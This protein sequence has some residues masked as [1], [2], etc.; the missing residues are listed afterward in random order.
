MS[1]Q[2]LHGVGPIRSAPPVVSG[3]NSDPRDHGHAVCDSHCEC[4]TWVAFIQ[5]RPLR[6]VFRREG[7]YWAALLA[8][9][10]LYWVIARQP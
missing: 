1:R 9:P 4:H 6:R 2:G 10:V 7:W 3:G 8:C 5:P